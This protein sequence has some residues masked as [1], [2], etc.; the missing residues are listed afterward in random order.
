MNTVDRS[1]GPLAFEQIIRFSGAVQDFNP[2]HYDEAF[3]KITEALARRGKSG[4]KRSIATS[5]SRLGDVQADRGQYDA[6]LA[7]HR[8]KRG[9]GYA[10]GAGDRQAGNA[11]QAPAQAG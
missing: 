5:L 3:A 8:R 9:T 11:V 6:A 7:C 4:D 2:I 10:Y 1:L